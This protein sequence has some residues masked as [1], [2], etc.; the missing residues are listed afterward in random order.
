MFVYVSTSGY[1]MKMVI[2]VFGVYAHPSKKSMILKM[3]IRTNLKYVS[4]L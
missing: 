4:Y 2:D 3:I 1:N